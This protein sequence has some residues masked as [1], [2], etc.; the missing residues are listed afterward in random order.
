M[1]PHYR[2]GGLVLYPTAPAHEILKHWPKFFSQV[3]EQALLD[4][5]SL[6][7]YRHL[8]KPVSRPPR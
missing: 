8:G 5:F 4:P 6:F 1:S 3:R 2:D 7:E